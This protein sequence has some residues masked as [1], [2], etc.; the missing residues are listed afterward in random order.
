MSS[1]A[2]AITIRPVERSDLAAVAD[3]I[4]RLAD[5]VRP[6]FT[7]GAD[8]ASLAR[9]GPTG[10]GLFEAVIATRED[11]PVG[12][13]LYTYAF[14][15]WRGRPGVFVEDLYVADAA[16]GTG[17]GRALLAAVIAREA[18]RGCCF[19]KL[20]VDKSNA[21]AH[22][23]YDRLGFAPEAHDDTLLL[24]EDGLRAIVGGE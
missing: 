20:Q 7:P 13:C 18:P 10:L 24:E 2:G 12:M 4:A 21:A 14:S 8:E 23:F 19:L 3:M 11:V 9:Y 17:L 16:R 15:G 22:A 5:H 1:T 6:G